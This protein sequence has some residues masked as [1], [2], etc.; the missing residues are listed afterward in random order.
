MSP[1]NYLGNFKNIVPTSSIDGIFSNGSSTFD[2]ISQQLM[3]VG[4][5]G[6]IMSSF[7]GVF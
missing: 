3:K 1:E 2:T 4:N 6:G 5:L 7:Q